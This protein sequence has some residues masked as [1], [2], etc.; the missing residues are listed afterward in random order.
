[1]LTSTERVAARFL[2]RQADAH[3]DAARTTKHLP[4]LM[5]STQT[6]V[7]ELLGH[8]TLMDALK[9][10]GE[11]RRLGRIQGIRVSDMRWNGK[12]IQATVQGSR[13]DSYTT[14][15]TI[16]PRGHRC[17]CPDWQRRGKAVGP[18]KHVLALGNRWLEERV[19]PAL[20][21]LEGRLVSVLEHAS[22]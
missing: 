16:H 7:T 4:G 18:C 22:L 11:A 3:E 10:A 20:E 14:R 2:R 8:V 5:S 15:I 13:G 6:W 17:T 21:G 19:V 1:V 9:A 12:R